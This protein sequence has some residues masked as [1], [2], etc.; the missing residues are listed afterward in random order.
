MII[1][2]IQTV[3]IEVEPIHLITQLRRKTLPGYSSYRSDDYGRCIGEDGFWYREV[4]DPRDGSFFYHKER[5]AS[6]KEKE[7]ELAFKCLFSHFVD[8]NK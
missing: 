7:L 2:G 5:E 6:E 4:Q 3:K 1:E 8:N